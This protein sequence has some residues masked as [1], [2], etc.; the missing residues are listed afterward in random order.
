MVCSTGG[1]LHLIVS[2]TLP[3]FCIHTSVAATI[4][5]FTAR[6][7]KCGS[8]DEP[9]Q[10]LFFNSNSTRQKFLHLDFYRIL[11]V[12]PVVMWEVIPAPSPELCSFSLLLVAVYLF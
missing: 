7:C 1:T 9:L 11:R 5:I 4:F 6:L 12:G 10:L 3:D 8:S 2:H